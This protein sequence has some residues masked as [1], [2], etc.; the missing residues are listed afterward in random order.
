M[1]PDSNAA[2]CRMFAWTLMW[3]VALAGNV[4]IAGEFNEVLS[5]GDAAPSWSDLPGTDD[6][7]HSLADL[8]NKQIVVVVFTCRSCPTAVDYEE[9]IDTLAAKYAEADSPVGVVAICV[10]NVPKD[11]LPDLKK[12]AEEAK[13]HFSYMH[14]ESQK[15]A[16]DFGALFTPQFFVLDK[17]RKIVYMGAM[18][19]ATEAD[20][21]TKHYVEDAI[22]AS[23]DGKSPEVKETIARGCR[24]R[25]AKRRK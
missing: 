25:F 13:L 5:V 18:D 8:S 22:A 21:V 19:D 10:N 9:R 14:D 24:I 3:L 1:L 4:S 16:T 2:I 20:K 6:K 23:L 17:D 12:H 7:S 11:T 15:V